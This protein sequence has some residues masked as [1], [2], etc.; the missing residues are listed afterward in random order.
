M[1]NNINV[2][3][4]EYDNI[5]I[6]SSLDSLIDHLH[7]PIQDIEIENDRLKLLDI[8]NSLLSPT[9]IGALDL[10]SVIPARK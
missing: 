5:S 8:Y 4:E 1:N 9:S 6:I 3:Y 7:T 2:S 10:L